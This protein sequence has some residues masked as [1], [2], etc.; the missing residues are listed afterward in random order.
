MDTNSPELQRLY[1]SAIIMVDALVQQPVE[2]QY[3]IEESKLSLDEILKAASQHIKDSSQAAKT[4]PSKLQP[5]LQ[6]I[7]EG[8]RSQLLV[9]E[10]IRVVKRPKTIVIEEL[11]V[12]EYTGP[13]TH[14]LIRVERQR[15]VAFVCS[16]QPL[17]EFFSC[18]VPKRCPICR[19]INPIK[20]GTVEGEELF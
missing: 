10:K 9:N 18:D 2:A 12:D 8:K 5:R 17:M 19:Q 3:V 11:V 15:Y 20:M 6:Q 4:S 14:T 7:A 1:K 13:K 16:R